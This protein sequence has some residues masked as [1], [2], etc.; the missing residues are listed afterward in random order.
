M[1]QKVQSAVS[2]T[3]PGT[4]VDVGEFPDVETG[5]LPVSHFID[6]T[7]QDEGLQPDPNHCRAGG[8]IEKTA[9]SDPGCRGSIA[10]RAAIALIRIYQK[11]ISPWLPCCCRFEPS[12]SHYGAE[13]FR[14][15][16]FLAGLILTI[17]RVMR[18]QPFCRGGYDPVPDKGFR[19]VT[20]D[21][22]SNCD[23]NEL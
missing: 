23:K 15:R 17:W 16:G 21:N 20:C 2:C 4:P 14:K 12:C 7:T 9:G 6:T 3:Q 22:Q 18:C 10:A 1:Q 5:T 8:N 19:R 11:M 13:A